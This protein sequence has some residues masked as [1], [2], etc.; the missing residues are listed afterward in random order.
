MVWGVVLFVW[1][2]YRAFLHLPEWIDELFIKPLIFLVPVLLFV[3]W[4]EKKSFASIG[5]LLGKFNRDLYIGLGIGAIFVVE[6]IV[7]NGVK[8]GTLTIVPAIPLATVTIVSY[9]FFSLTS[10]FCEETLVRGFLFSR[11]RDNYQNQIKAVVVS[12]LMYFFLLVP[13][14]FTQLSLTPVSLAIFIMTNLILSF[15][16]SMIFSETKTLTIP[17]LIHTFWNMTVFMYL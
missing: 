13:V 6:A 10:S 8:Y 14:I 12:T 16:N 15:A 9:L 5:W 7:A 2:L 11:L 1:A 17:V 4:Y 3:R